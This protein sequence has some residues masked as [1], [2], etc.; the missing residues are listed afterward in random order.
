[1]NLNLI[2]N[3]FDLY[4]GLP[5]SYYYFGCYLIETDHEF[6]EEIGKIYNLTNK[7]MVEPYISHEYE[8]AVEDL[9]WSNFES[10]LATVDEYFVVES[11]V[12]DLGLEIPDPV[13]LEINDDHNADVLK[14]KFCQ[15]VIDTLDIDDNYELIRRHLLINNYL[16]I[17]ADDYFLQFNYTHSLQRLYDV[18]DEMIH[19]VHGE[20]LRPDDELI[21][22]HGND[23]V[24]RELSE[25]IEKLNEEYD[26]TQAS[27][28]RIAEYR[29]VLE[30]VKKLRKNVKRCMVDCDNFYGKIDENIDCIC[31]YGLSLGEVDVPYLVQIRDRWPEAKWRFSY[32]D[33]ADKKR[34]QKVA[35][36]DLMLKDNE[37][38][39]FRLVNTDSRAICNEIVQLRGI[40][41]HERV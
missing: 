40:I 29:C 24:I 3:G 28:N 19:Y 21:I 11:S 18:N 8:H 37:F 30:Y 34:I 12:D 13:D 10:R 41:E 9:F 1:M 31:L 25:K 2:G 17:N 6:F 22:G 33:K 26:Y 5:S 27:N 16:H 7:I 4:H 15:W 35:R 38:S 39:T 36:N 14:M 23:I 20:C 32:Y